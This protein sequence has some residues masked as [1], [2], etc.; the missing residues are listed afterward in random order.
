MES[1]GF[2]L[3]GLV[4]G[5]AVGATGVGGGSLMT[6]ILILFYGITPAI[7]VGTDLLYASISKAFAVALHGKNGSVD[8]K[9]VGWLSVGSV[10]AALA[11]LAFIHYYGQSGDLDRLIKLTLSVAIVLTALGTIFRGK[12]VAFAKHERF[13]FLRTLHRRGQH[14]FTALSGAAIGALVTISSVGAGVI[15]MML[16][17]LLYPRHSAIKLVGSDLAHAVLITGIAGL[18][19]AS[20]GTVNYPMLGAL[21]IGAVPGIYLGTRVGFRLPDAKLRPLI[22]GLLLFIGVGM[23][24]KAIAAQF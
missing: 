5:T 24:G 15:G 22:A 18:G 6:P 23:L 20:L 1:L 9:I 7:A 19:H 13:A 4:V 2:A 8:W 21:L 3:A 11:T 10:P 14:T 16:L 12:L 17:L